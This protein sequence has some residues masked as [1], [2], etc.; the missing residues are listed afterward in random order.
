[1]GYMV[2]CKSKIEIIKK[3]LRELLKPQTT[4]SI[5]ENSCKY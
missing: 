5:I 2:A 1:M 3:Q 4:T